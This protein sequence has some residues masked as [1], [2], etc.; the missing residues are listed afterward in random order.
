MSQWPRN[1]AYY[2]WNDDAT[3]TE[4]REGITWDGYNDIIGRLERAWQV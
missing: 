1:I 4:T 3:E 2:Y